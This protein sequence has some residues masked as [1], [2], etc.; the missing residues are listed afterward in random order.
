M[1]IK[2]ALGTISFSA[3]TLEP[4]FYLVSSPSVAFAGF[5]IRYVPRI[6]ISI[7]LWAL[8]AATLW[9]FAVLFFALP[10]R[11]AAPLTNWIGRL[12][13]F[14]HGCW[15]HMWLP[16][17]TSYSRTLRMVWISQV[18]SSVCI[19]NIKLLQVLLGQ[20]KFTILKILLNWSCGTSQI[21][22]GISLSHKIL[23]GTLL[24][25]GLIVIHMTMISCSWMLVLHL[26][27]CAFFRSTFSTMTASVSFL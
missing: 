5:V 23:E 9:T 6:L 22:I 26:M 20:L 11:L 14:Q 19:L 24:F 21:I 18:D 7:I 25:F 13:T 3:P 27:N 10:V 2:A 16:L 1:L 8:T 4:S 15:V 17:T 12:A